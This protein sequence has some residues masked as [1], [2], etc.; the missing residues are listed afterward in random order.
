MGDY[1]L[2]LLI[3]LVVASIVRGD[4]TFTVLYLIIGA[5]VIGRWWS[6]RAL[7]GIIFH[8]DF[9]PHAFLGE[10]VP[11][12]LKIRNS[13][14]LPVVW[15]RV[16]E[17]LPVELTVPNAVN[18]VIT[19]GVRGQS[20]IRYILYARKRGYYPIGPLFIAT[21]DLLGLSRV[22]QGCGK[23]DHLTV[24]PHIIP[25][26]RPRLPS[27]S[28]QGALR[29]NQ[30][31]FEDPSRVLSKRDYVA[32]DS[33]KRVDWKA[34]ASVGHLQVKQF[35][36]SIAL[37]T[38]IF[39]NLHSLEYDSHYRIDSTELAIVI[40]A[41]LANWLV[42]KKQSV[43]LVTN[44]VDQLAPNQLA[45]PLPPHKGRGNLIH[46][47]EALARLQSAETV[48][49]ADLVRRESPHLAWGTTLVVI[50]GRVDEI[51]FDELFQARRRGLN[52]MIVLAGRVAGWRDIQ[53]KADS[54]GFPAYAFQNERDL[55]VWR[56]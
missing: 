44:G 25:L 17:S 37:E 43:G 36:P 38:A 13:S 5:Y 30:P 10:D 41:S 14:W 39:L 55:N 4:F 11:V 20:T 9:E 15:L 42:G 26:T 27:H 21:G 23:I 19:L 34:S 1:W 50:T 2:F 18:Q 32:G 8:R 52:A 3:V 46:V 16:N 29:S 22:Q 6:G 45:R 51:L 47:L 24:Y 49:I 56:Q 7:A 12:Q 31:I 54:F 35:E 33:L 40:A 48:P 28:P 53:H